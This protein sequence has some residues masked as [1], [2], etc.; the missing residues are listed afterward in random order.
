MDEYHKSQKSCISMV[1]LIKRKIKDFVQ[2]LARLERQDQTPESR[3]KV[4]ELQFRITELK[5]KL[6]ELEMSLPSSA[7][8]FLRLCLGNI[9]VSLYQKKLEYK[10]NYETFKLKMTVLCLVFAFS[11]L[12]I[13][14]Y[15][16]TDS[17]FHG[18]LVWYYSTLTLQEHIL[19]ANGSRIKGW[20]VLH[21]Y[22]SILLSG[23]LL[24]WPEGTIYQ[25]FRGQFFVFS[26]YLSFVQLIQYRYQSGVLY[27]LR[28]LGV[29]YGMDVT[30]DGFHTWMFRGLGFVLPFLIFGY[31]F[32]LYNAYTLFVF[33]HH[34]SCLEWQVL[35]LSITFF[36][37]FFGNM[38]TLVYVMRS[39]YKQT[40]K[41][42]FPCN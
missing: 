38:T 33:F 4:A 14:N 29:S 2:S 42:K 19:I 37:L 13:C 20:W 1:N 27:R 8:S 11:N 32:Q 39:K 40:H 17:I 10:D 16:I 9:D 26:C 24:I 3:K 28:A 35:A 25:M 41:I 34:P 36:V 12:Y 7:G 23:L 5:N 6:K 18:I 15:R 22:F 31:L 21:H 30:L